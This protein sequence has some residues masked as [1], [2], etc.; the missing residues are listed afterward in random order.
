MTAPV[1]VRHPLNERILDDK[2]AGAIARVGGLPRGSAAAREANPVAGNDG[3]SAA[4]QLIGSL[5]PSIGIRDRAT[6]ADRD[7]LEQLEREL[8]ELLATSAPNAWRAMRRTVR[9]LIRNARSEI[10]G[11]RIQELAP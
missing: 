6:R 5:L 4:P 2:L 1:R 8:T 7:R 11:R 9:R 10:R 3:R